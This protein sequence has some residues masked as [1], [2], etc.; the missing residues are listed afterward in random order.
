MAGK[1][2]PI[3]F[4]L[5]VSLL[6]LNGVLGMNASYV[7]AKYV[8]DSVAVDEIQSQ[9]FDVRY[10]FPFTA[11]SSGVFTLTEA[12]YSSGFNLSVEYKGLGKSYIRIL[13]QESWIYEDASGTQT[14][15]MA[16]GISTYTPAS[17]D[18][19]DNRPADGY[20]YIKGPTNTG[21]DTVYTTIPVI[22][23]ATKPAFPA[24][25]TVTH[26]K[27]SI[28]VDAVQYNRYEQFWG[29]GSLPY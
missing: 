20:V 3:I 19:V 28:K 2:K 17:S 4:I 6:V 16:S 5:I 25:T 27:I 23:G 29:P 9:Y 8:D 12:E 7:L 1:K 18:I 14:V 21:S 15:V 10:V 24:G 26:V 13:I 22:T 11:D